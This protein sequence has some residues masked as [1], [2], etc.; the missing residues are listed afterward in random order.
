[1]YGHMK[2]HTLEY[3]HSWVCMCYQG[4]KVKKLISNIGQHSICPF[5]RIPTFQIYQEQRDWMFMMGKDV[6]VLLKFLLKAAIITRAMSSFSSQ[7]YTFSCNF[8]LYD[9]IHMSYLDC[10]I[11]IFHFRTENGTYIQ[12]FFS[13]SQIFSFWIE[14]NRRVLSLVVCNPL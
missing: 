3:H 2:K 1:M 10:T 12:T 8:Y 11:K 4:G 14:W 6:S 5:C 9:T 13:V 7:G